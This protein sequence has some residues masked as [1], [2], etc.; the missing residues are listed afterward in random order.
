[1][2]LCWRPLHLFEEKYIGFF[3]HEFIIS[4]GLNGNLHVICGSPLA[5]ELPK[6]TESTT[7]TTTT[8]IATPSTATL[9]LSPLVSFTEPTS[10]I[11]Q[12]D[13]NVTEITATT[14]SEECICSHKDEFT[15][16]YMYNFSKPLKHKDKML[17]LSK[18]LCLLSKNQF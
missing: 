9:R 13:V 16:N 11:I 3:P 4:G 6:T 12:N 7:T 18:E 1:M 14:M 15:G 5:T 10:A 8:T 2:F 17:A